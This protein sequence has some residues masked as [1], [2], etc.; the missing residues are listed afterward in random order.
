MVAISRKN[1]KVITDF[2]HTIESIV[3]ILTTPKNTRLY[4]RNF[5]AI[6]FEKIDA[7]INDNLTLEIYGT[8]VAAL[9]VET[10]VKIDKVS[11]N[12]E[13]SAEGK[14]FIDIFAIYLPDGRYITLEGLQ[15]I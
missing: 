7:I 9:K 4:R 14:L 13:L 15:V 12:Q 5:G 8:T 1:G 2:E 3:T 11:V 10:R 6:S